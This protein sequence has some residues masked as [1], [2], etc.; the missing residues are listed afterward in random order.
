[1]IE[2]DRDD[3]PH[4]REIVGLH[5]DEDIGRKTIHVLHERAQRDNGHEWNLL[6]HELH[7]PIARLSWQ[8]DC[9]DEKLEVV[10]MPRREKSNGVVAVGQR[11]NGVSQVDEAFR[12]PQSVGSRMSHENHSCHLSS[13]LSAWV[14]DDLTS[15]RTF[16]LLG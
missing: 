6:S 9:R 3:V 1:M 2:S 10:A 4:E 13:F 7:D 8:V 15:V 14:C 5:H 11:R 12:N 16:R